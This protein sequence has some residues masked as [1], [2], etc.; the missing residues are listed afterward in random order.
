MLYSVVWDAKAY[1]VLE[2]ELVCRHITCGMYVQAPAHRHAHE[3]GNEAGHGPD[4][5]TF[6]AKW[7]VH[8]K[9]PLTVKHK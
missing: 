3:V 4:I 5:P 1:S 9:D 8:T 6:D 2:G 7:H